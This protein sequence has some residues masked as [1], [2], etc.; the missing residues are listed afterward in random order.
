MNVGGTLAKGCM[1][2]IISM[3]Y[4]KCD[5]T[6]LRCNIRP[7]SLHSAGLD[8]KLSSSSLSSSSEFIVVYHFQ[9]LI[10]K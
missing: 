9:Y 2:Y 5:A 4:I 1:Q 3:G 7:R 10:V 8:G 6:P